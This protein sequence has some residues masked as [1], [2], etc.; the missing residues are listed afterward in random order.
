MKEWWVALYI[1]NPDLEGP[2]DS[3]CSENP[4]HKRMIGTEVLRRFTVILDYA[5]NRIILEPNAQFKDPFPD[6]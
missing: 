5:R 6:A 3:C 4:D 2:I 1:C